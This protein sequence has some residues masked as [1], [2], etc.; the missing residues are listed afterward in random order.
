MA[1]GAT[2]I[3]SRWEARQE[4][5]GTAFPI[6]MLRYDTMVPATENDAHRI[7]HAVTEGTTTKE[8]IHLRRFAQVGAGEPNYKR[9][10][11]Y[12]WTVFRS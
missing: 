6:D 8:N 1:K 7:E 5:K 11:S 10:E 3:E 4:R 9:W 2:H 12:G